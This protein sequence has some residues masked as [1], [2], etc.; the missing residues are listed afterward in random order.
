MAP[1]E[2]HPPRDTLVR[3]GQWLVATIEEMSDDTIAAN[4]TFL[5]HAG[6]ALALWRGKQ[7]ADVDLEL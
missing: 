6:R 4:Y 2:S 3:A 5:S 1:R 7:V